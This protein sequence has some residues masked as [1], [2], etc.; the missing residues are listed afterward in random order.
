MQATTKNKI[1]MFHLN[2]NKLNEEKY[3]LFNDNTVT[4]SKYNFFTFL[5]KCL[6]L[7]F[8]R[9]ANIYF[10][11]IACIQSIP[12]ISPLNPFTAVGPMI[13]VLL[14]SILREGWEDHKRHE[15]DNSMNNE[16]VLIYC[17]QDKKW[18][19]SK[20]K[21]IRLGEFVLLKENETTPADI[22]L[23]D[24]NNSE[25]IC[26]VETSNLDGEKTL[27]KRF[28]NSKTA[29]IINK[30]SSMPNSLPDIKGDVQCDPPNIELYKFEGKVDMKIENKPFVLS[31]NSKMLL[32]KGSKIKSTKWAIGFAVY[33]GHN[34]KLIKNTKSPQSKTSSLE[35]FVSRAVVGILVF[36]IILCVVSAISYSI[37]YSNIKENSIY[38]ELK[39]DD[40][41]TDS[42][43]SYF[44]YMLLLNTM[45]PISLILTL[46]M[47]KLVQGYFMRY[48]YGLYSI[49]KKEYPK[50]GSVSINEELGQ[51][52][53][54]FS[55]KTG[56]LTKNKMIFK[57]CVIG[58]NIYELTE[59]NSINLIN[60]KRN[61]HILTNIPSANQ[62]NQNIENS[63]MPILN[64]DKENNMLS[65]LNDR[66]KLDTGERENVNNDH[67]NN[68]NRK[69]SDVLILQSNLVKSVINNNHNNDKITLQKQF[70]ATCSPNI[71]DKHNDLKLKENLTDHE[72]ETRI[73]KRSKTIDHKNQKSKLDKIT[74]RILN[75]NIKVDICDSPNKS[76]LMNQNKLKQWKT[77][78]IKYINFINA[79]SKKVTTVKRFK[80]KNSIMSPNKNNFGEEKEIT[81]RQFS[82]RDLEQNFKLITKTKTESEMC[83][84]GIGYM[85]DFNANNKVNYPGNIITSAD[86]KV[87]LDLSNENAIIHHYWTALAL[88]NECI[89]EKKQNK[90]K[91]KNNI[92]NLNFSYSGM[93]PD[94]IEL[95]YTTA[96]QGYELSYADH[97]VKRLNVGMS[98]VQRKEYFILQMMEF[99]SDRKRMSI[100]LQDPSGMIIMYCKGADSIIYDNLHPKNNYNILLNNSKYS[101]YYSKQGYRTL[102]VGMKIFSQEE[103]NVVEKTL[104]SANL[105]LKGRQETIDKIN[106]EIESNLFL[107]GSTIVEDELQNFVPETIRDLRIAHIKIWMLT[108]DKMDTAYSI[109]LSCNLITPKMKTFHLSGEK[110]DTLEKLIL[111]FNDFLRTYNENDSF[112]LIRR[113]TKTS[114]HNENNFEGVVR[115]F[116]SVSVLLRTATQNL[117]NDKEALDKSNDSFALVVDSTA[118][119]NILSSPDNT[120][121][122]LE[123]AL[124]AYA[125]ICCRISPLQKSEIVKSVKTFDSTIISLSI[126]DGGN[127]VSMISEANIGIGLYGE[128][129]MRAV[130]ASD[131]AIGEFHLLRRLLLHSGRT[132]LMRT[133]NMIL[134]FF[135]K[136]FIITIIHFYFG[137]YN[138]FSGQTIIDDWFIAIYNMVLTALPLCLAAV[139]DFDFKPEDSIV[140]DKLLPFLYC[141]MR[142]DPK[143]TLKSFLLGNF[144]GIIQGAFIFFTAIKLMSNIPLDGSGDIADL[145]YFSFIIYTSV[146]FTISFKLL[147]QMSYFTILI[148]IVM[149]GFSWFL[150]I[151]VIMLSERMFLFNSVATGSVVFTNI[152]TYLILIVF[153]GTCFISD[154]ISKAIRF[155]FTFGLRE[156]LLKDLNLIQEIS[157]KGKKA[158]EDYLPFYISEMLEEYVEYELEIVKH[159]NDVDNYENELLDKYKNNKTEAP[160][161]SIFEKNIIEESKAFDNELNNARDSSPAVPTMIINNL[162]H[163][164]FSQSNNL[165]FGNTRNLLSPY[166][167]SQNKSSSMASSPSVSMSKNKKS[168]SI[169]KDILIH[170]I[171][172]NFT[173]DKKSDYEENSNKRLKNSEVEKQN[174]ISDISIM[175]KRLRESPKLEVSEYIKPKINNITD[176]N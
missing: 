48:D 42:T 78:S 12:I 10:L 150:Y 39:A 109:G 151:I 50:I 3:F 146:I 102:S 84:V 158:F 38:L 132:N 43:L 129:G 81:L 64:K 176:K 101:S 90:D 55:D 31:L 148:V 136:N 100:I 96:K 165:N 33:I 70:N 127:D 41:T 159:F 97:R 170:R 152:S 164:S 86:G 95:V 7:Q 92:K 18:K 98:S 44:T 4:L 62:S 122:F 29:G 166:K 27:K 36:Q 124:R 94:D 14:A 149:G 32:L 34:C 57:F 65:K 52:T 133:S 67:N 49:T 22:V 113:Y 144:K 46:E 15:F 58:E 160:K 126:G 138:N 175:K 108:G 11:I 61:S 112:G 110:G 139:Y 172:E 21:N 13:I 24:S 74:N 119:S 19:N 104:N 80:K 56:T 156:L 59:D 168:G 9:L 82:I 85:S 123:I 91:L 71:L 142:D 66:T 107:I 88:A 157:N 87:S 137:F 30:D 77:G 174:H 115:N 173:L 5:P 26:Y 143:L 145:W 116:N 99:S 37:Y 35:R 155:H 135:Y 69:G 89:V 54:I 68:S 25:G 60:N 79:F 16:E 63:K 134:Y 118:I 128:E 111:E 130:Q 167:F 162:K 2:N 23:F 140:L 53:H 47:V 106:A 125:V 105:L 93:S 121:L 154:Y 83:K 171:N 103:Y 8:M 40:K 45:I 28:P 1:Q 114:N 131:F 169:K 51:V 73:E 153:I 161:M 17:P 141:E 75:N 120:K 20:S 76:R 6:A 163:P 72:E 147:V 117:A